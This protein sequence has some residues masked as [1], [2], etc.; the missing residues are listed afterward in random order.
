[1][2]TIPDNIGPFLIEE[3]LGKGGMGVVYKARHASTNEIVALKTVRL[4]NEGFLQRIR[5]E[6][7][8]LTRIN[9]P[10]IV[11][12]IDSGIDEG[13]PWYAMEFVKGQTLKMFC[14]TS[15]IVDNG[16]MLESD[17]ET[18]DLPQN[19][20]VDSV[21]S[22][23]LVQTMDN[24]IDVPEDRSRLIQ[25][26]QEQLETPG[27]FPQEISSSTLNVILALTCRISKTL[28]YLHGEGI[29]HRDL[30]P[31]NILVTPDGIPILVDFGL[32]AHFR[33][34]MSREVLTVERGSVGTVNYMA[35]EQI[36]GDFVDARADLYALGCIFYELLTGR[37]P[38]VSKS[39]GKVVT[40]HLFK[41]V[42]PPSYFVRGLPP[43]IDNLI[44]RLLAKKPHDRLGYSDDVV[45][46]LINLGASES[47]SKWGPKPRIYL[48]RPEFSIHD[49]NWRKL[50]N[51][52]KNLRNN[53]GGVLFVVG[54]NG[55]GKTRLVMEIGN[56]AIREDILVLP[57][58][59]SSIG[60]APLGAFSRPLQIIADQCREKDISET[61]FLLGT[62]GKLLALYESSLKGLPGLKA[63]PEPAELD[64]EANRLR[65]YNYLLETFRQL[66]SRTGTLLI[67]DD[68]HWADDLSIG[69]IEFLL[70]GNHLQ[71]IPLLL[72][73]TIR[74]DLDHSRFNVLLEQKNCG[75]LTVE[76]LDETAV[77][78]MI[79]DM[80]ALPSPP[81][82]FSYY[83]SRL[84]EGNPFFVSEYLRTAVEESLLW[85][86]RDGQ[87]NVTELDEK[88]KVD[89]EKLPL[90]KSLQTL[91]QGRLEKLPPMSRA[92]VRVIATVGRDT[93]YQILE[94]TTE[95]TEYDLIKTC[96]ELLR[97]QILEQ[98]GPESI[99]FASIKLREVAYENIPADV[100]KKLHRTLASIFESRVSAGSIDYLTETAYH[101]EKAEELAKAQDFYLQSA[102]REKE[103]YAYHDAEQLYLAFLNLEETNGERVVDVRNELGKEVLQ[104]Q[105]RNAEAQKEHERALA[106]AQSISYQAGIAVSTL[107]LGVIHWQSGRINEAEALYTKALNLYEKLGDQ[108]SVAITLGNLAKLYFGLGQLDRALDLMEESLSIHQKMGNHKQEGFIRGNIANIYYS[109]GEME[110]AHRLYQ[111]VIDLFRRIGDKRCEGLFLGNLA[112]LFFNQSR[113][114]KAREFYEQALSLDR[115][116]GDRRLEGIIMANLGS[117]SYNLG[118]ME[119]SKKYYE[120][121][122][123]ILRD[124][125]DRQTEG[126][127]TGNLANVYHALGINDR[128]HSLLKKALE[129]A[130]EVGDHLFEGLTMGNLAELE[131]ELGNVEESRRLFDRALKFQRD[132]KNRLHEGILLASKANLIRR[133]TD[134]FTDV[135]ELLDLS[136][137]C[138]SEVGNNLFLAIT[139]CGKGYLCLAQGKSAREYI[140]AVGAIQGEHDLERNQLLA[141]EIDHLKE[142]EETF[143]S[144]ETERLFK[145]EL[146]DNLPPGLLVWLS[147][148]TLI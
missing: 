55:V 86:E 27:V 64:A 88:G 28:A 94:K 136:E 9:H 89:Y 129:I 35:P 120:Q 26:D 30:K 62:R 119:Q 84:S 81:R 17:C 29:V 66:T 48:Y 34:E 82:K 104:I 139:L 112:N 65:L 91:L 133:T 122:L 37:P 80:L 56:R 43:R 121:A 113:L 76:R 19:E 114:R 58:E 146:K 44:L 33:R 39:V 69:F 5:R 6:I 115:E 142:A 130:K 99:R 135:S 103:R 2:D 11:R 75:Q 71:D 67:L 20:D 8:A 73:G 143:Q 31:D 132:V 101:W 15:G 57:G 46:E 117:V 16:L 126:M 36:R 124:I 93:D 102:R 22:P 45:E 79:G 60:L 140:E 10:G 97:S 96:E 95:L 110:K 92:I 14:H 125:N 78:A 47:I 40:C 42:I 137:T 41:P 53:H 68:L 106:A 72:L 54:E 85:R 23:W 59:C 12:I 123:T 1:M 116:V 109:R 98:S 77:R 38:F 63:Y 74:S 131:A 61:E 118:D 100:R 18:E 7:V 141:K 128:A 13:I 147:K 70:K 127:A 144:G 3:I 90:P 107:Y 83:M 111:D 4:L 24:P 134:H 49:Q 138:L 148:K 32:M 50:E 108:T 51:S 25:E 52:Y 105:G 21:V 145:G 87:W